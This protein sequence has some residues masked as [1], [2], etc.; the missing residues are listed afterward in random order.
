METE[1]GGVTTMATKYHKNFLTKD[2]AFRE[3]G[4]LNMDLKRKC[5][6]SASSSD[7]TVTAFLRQPDARAVCGLLKDGYKDCRTPV[8]KAINRQQE[9]RFYKP[10]T[11]ADP[12]VPVLIHDLIYDM[13][14]LPEIKAAFP[15]AKIEESWDE[16]HEGRFSVELTSTYT[17]YF[18]KIIKMGMHGISFHCQLTLH[19]G[20]DGSAAFP[21]LKAAIDRLK[22][23]QGA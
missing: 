5:L 14:A 1:L 7:M 22:A 8:P 3:A 17:E 10:V 15:D 23:E 2:E 4:R 19:M 12:D 13:A 21:G 20:S 11:P 6:G 16:I 9:N 18:Y